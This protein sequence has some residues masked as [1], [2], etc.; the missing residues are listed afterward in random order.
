[1]GLGLQRM[2]VRG[3]INIQSVAIHN[4]NHVAHFWVTGPLGGSERL[5]HL[6]SSQNSERAVILSFF[7]F[8]PHHE[9]C[10]ILVPQPWIKPAPLALEG[11]VLATGLPEKSQEPLFQCPYAQS[12]SCVLLFAT[13]WTEAQQAPLSM[14][15]S[16][17]G[18]SPI[19]WTS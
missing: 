17:Q 1:M 15:F 9:A 13:P 8:K 6:E 7:L 2:A 5:V 11:R 14:G 3:D 18:S 4:V 19:N 12:L 16:R 10:G